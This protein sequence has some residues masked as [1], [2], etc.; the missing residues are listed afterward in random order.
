M[1][2]IIRNLALFLLTTICSAMPCIADNQANEKAAATV[3]Y[4]D[5]RDPFESFNRAMWTFNY[6][7]LDRYLFRPIAHG[8]KN[9]VPDPVKTGSNN[10]VQ[11]LDEPSSMLNNLLQMKWLWAAN[12]GGRFVINSTLGLAGLVDVASMMGMERKQ[13]DFSEV[14]AYYG[15]PNGPY[16]MAPF[17]GPQTTLE[18]TTDWVDGLYFPIS[19]FTL[20]QTSLKWGLENLHARAEAIDQE[21]LIENSLDPYSFVK[22][23]YFQHL[24]YRVLDGEISLDQHDDNDDLLDEYLDELE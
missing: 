22:D 18:L 21:S 23:A 16:I 13:D 24:D 2:L 6:N 7:Y 8:Y 11:N 17:L 14:L 3:T 9:Y 15:A 1:I 12:A 20:L 4:N 10:F 5:P 19:E